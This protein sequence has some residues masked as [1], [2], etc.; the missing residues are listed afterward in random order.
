MHPVRMPPSWVNARCQEIFK[1]CPWK[2]ADVII[3]N[4]WVSLVPGR[5][6]PGAREVRRLYEDLWGRTG[7]PNPIIPGSRA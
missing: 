2:L 4:D 7:P 5:Q 1:V 3:N 6:P